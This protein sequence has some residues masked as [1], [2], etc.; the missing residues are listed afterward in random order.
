MTG[1]PVYVDPDEPIITV[2]ERML[3]E[4]VRH[5]PVVSDG[6]VIGVVSVRDALR[7]AARTAWRRARPT[8]EA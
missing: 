6:Q 7:A 3:D 1:E 8:E 5:L 2:A 4:G